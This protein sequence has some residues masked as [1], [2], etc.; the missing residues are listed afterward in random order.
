MSSSKNFGGKKPKVGPRHELESRSGGR[1]SPLKETGRAESKDE[2]G[3]PNRFVKLWQ[4][5]PR[6]RRVLV[7]LGAVGVGFGI[8]FC[9]QWYFAPPP[10]YSLSAIVYPLGSGTVSANHGDYS[11]GTQITLRATPSAD[12]QFVS[13]S[14]DAVGTSPEA[15]VSMDSDKSV[16]AN[17]RIIEYSL[18][19]QVSPAEAG[20]ISPGGGKYSSGSSVTLN[21]TASAGYEFVSWSG[22]AVGTGPE[23]KV[24]M[25]SDKSVVANFRIAEYSLIARVS[26]AEAGQISPGG[27]KYSSGSSVTL[28]ATASAGYEF[29]SWFGDAAGTSPEVVVKV[30]SN[31]SVVAHFVPV[32]QRITYTMESG[33]SGS[34]VVYT[35]ELEG[36]EIVE[37]FAELAGKFYAQDW[38]FRWTLEI[39]GPEGRKMYSWYRGHWVERN[40]REFAFRAPYS[41]SYKIRVT[42]NSLHDKYLV[43]E[44]EPKGW[45][46]KSP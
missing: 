11:E 10:T 20:Q 6:W 28:T 21:A 12:Y 34:A 13:W 35:N 5:S 15:T 9:A 27:G 19:A 39:F 8:W 7:I 17:F 23:T 16:V 4:G 2:A 22:D 37:G 29:V 42:H 25:D 14:G 36:G 46:L 43:I 3:K 31:K 32:R 40:R 24:S 41:G 38:T 1:R 18:A 33:I 45:I 44:I 26:P 30:D